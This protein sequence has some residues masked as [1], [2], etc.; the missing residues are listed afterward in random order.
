MCNIKLFAFLLDLILFQNILIS[1][2]FLHICNFDGSLSRRTS[3]NF[4]LVVKQKSLLIYFFQGMFVSWLTTCSVVN[5]SHHELVNCTTS[6]WRAYKTCFLSRNA[7]STVLLTYVW[8]ISK[9]SSSS[10]LKALAW[11]LLILRSPSSNELEVIYLLIY[12]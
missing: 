4:I 10:T 3:P 9:L 2:I 12:S 5:N 1:L 11:G 7:R 6:A 8:Q